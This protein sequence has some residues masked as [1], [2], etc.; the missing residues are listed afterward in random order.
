MFLSAVF[1]MAILKVST[2]NLVEQSWTRTHVVGHR[3]AAAYAPENSLESFELAAEVGAHAVECDVHMSKDGR[4][5][6][7]HDSTLQRTTKLTGEVKSFEFY[8][9]LDAG[10]PSLDQYISVLK[11]KS[12]Q[13]I[14]I[15]A[16]E[17]VVRSSLEAVQVQKTLDQTVFFS[18]NSEYVKEVKELEPKA[19][20]VWLVSGKYNK[21]NFGDLAQRLKDIDADAVGFGYKNL[22]GDV[23]ALL[24]DAKIPLFVW[25]VPPGEEVEKLK[26]LR[27]NFIISDHPQDLLK[28]LGFTKD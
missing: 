26:S 4:P 23:P 28:Q 11:N 25:T 14:E 24:R 10:V 9:L 15:K 21:E 2:V 22:D 20:A 6:V 7:I 17:N 16:G 12:V 8:D 19:F 3:G 5:V 1:G 18:F 13:V 27:V